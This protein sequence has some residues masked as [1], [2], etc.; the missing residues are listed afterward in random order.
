MGDIYF[1][2]NTTSDPTDFVFVMSVEGTVWFSP[3]GDFYGSIAGN[4]EVTLQPGCSLTWQD[5]TDESLSFPTGA[6]D[7]LQIRTWEV[8]LQ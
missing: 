5:W 3:G 6:V 2:P 8:S 1:N 4:V 7:S